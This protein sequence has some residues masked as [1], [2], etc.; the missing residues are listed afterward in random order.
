MKAI[1]QLLFFGYIL[2]ILFAC[3]GKLESSTAEKYIN[4]LDTLPFFN[5]L[6]IAKLYALADKVDVIF[7]NLPASV[8]QD[9]PESAKNTVLYIMPA[10]PTN[11]GKCGALGRLSWLSE[12]K[13][14]READFF[15]GDSCHY[16][17]FMKDGIPQYANQ[18]GKPGIE[19]FTT[20]INQ[21]KKTKE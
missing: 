7:Y 19:F 10:K 14:I 21:V 1:Y 3:K 20:I 4:P 17:L 15:V 5:N 13:I 11:R 8:S 12:G 6:E 16:L 9:D 18:M 2:S